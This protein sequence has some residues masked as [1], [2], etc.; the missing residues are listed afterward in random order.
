M[1]KHLASYEKLGHGRDKAPRLVKALESLVTD[2]R[3][4]I[5][6]LIS[7]TRFLHYASLC[8]SNT[9]SNGCGQRNIQYRVDTIFPWSPSVP[10]FA[11]EVLS[12]TPM[13]AMHASITTTAV[14]PAS[15]NLA[16]KPGCHCTT[17]DISV[18]CIVLCDV[19]VPGTAVLGMPSRHRHRC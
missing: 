10:R 2:L 12:T 3:C 17:S 14:E 11:I 9:V 18:K 19:C 8:N 4:H 6:K 16:R 15:G 13:K 7:N 5:R 1:V